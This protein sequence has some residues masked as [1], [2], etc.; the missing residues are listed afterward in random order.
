MR[1]VQPGV[2][3]LSNSSYT[4]GRLHCHDGSGRRFSHGDSRAVQD[5]TAPQCCSR[6]LVRA[7]ISRQTRI[8]REKQDTYRVAI[9]EANYCVRQSASRGEDESRDFDRVR[10]IGKLIDE[11]CGRLHCGGV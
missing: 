4:T 1:E 11:A 10:E 9:R 5:E 2:Y 3:C 8:Y 7:K 6:C